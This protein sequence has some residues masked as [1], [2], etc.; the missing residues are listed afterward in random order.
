[1]EV[2]PTADRGAGLYTVRHHKQGDLV[3]EYRGEVLTRLEIEGRAAMIGDRAWDYTMTLDTGAGSHK[4]A[5]HLI[6]DGT[7]FSSA[8]QYANHSCDGGACYTE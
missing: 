1:M 8:A 5:Q 3:V 7:H 6:L 2:R 4:R